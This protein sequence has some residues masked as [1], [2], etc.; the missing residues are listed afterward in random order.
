MRRD[1]TAVLHFIAQVVRSLAGFGTT[2]FAARYFGAAGLG[3]YSQVLALLF[4]LKFPSNSLTTAIS[5]R[6]SES[7]ET[8]GHFTAGL[9]AALSYGLLVAVILVVFQSVVSGYL[10]AEA[11]LPLIGLL[12]VNMTFDMVKSGF[13]GRKRV[14]ISGW[15]GTA[16]QILRLLGQVAFVLGG[17]LVIGLVYGHVLSLFV[18]ACLGLVLLRKQLRLPTRADF[19]DLRRF[20]QYSWLGDVKGLTLGWMDILVLGLFVTNDLVGIYQASWTLAS[21]LALTSKSIGTT[22]FPE[23]SELAAE[24]LYDDAKSLVGDAML[25]AG[26]FLIPGFFGALVVGDRVLEVY[27][28]EFA[29]G[30]TVLVLLIAARAT[31]AF[32]DQLVNAINGLDRPDVAFRINAAFLTTNTVLNVVLVWQFGWYGAAVATLS[33]TGVYLAGGWV[34][35]RRLVGALDFPFREVGYELL[36]AVV[37]SG[38]LYLAVPS[39]PRTL[40]VTILAVFVAAGIYSVVLLTLSSR[41]RGKVRT[42]VGG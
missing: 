6:M 7:E 19:D 37:M 9:L 3:V 21:F 12:L 23:L 39:L 20:A 10:G 15:L 30:G 34:G 27:D 42:V 5:K 8:T 4:W 28:T 18:F 1:R 35:F 31:H 11:T 36:A 13:V 26:V 16:E 17:A 22:L 41:I 38:L 40:P 29:A 32:G 33:S 14:A 25:F 24:D 2:L